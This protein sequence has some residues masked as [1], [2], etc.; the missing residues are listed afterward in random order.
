VTV[1]SAALTLE[2]NGRE[3]RDTLIRAWVV[4]IGA[5]TTHVLL[6]LSGAAGTMVVQV[7]PLSPENSI[8]TDSLTLAGVQ[9]II[10]VLPAAH[11]SSLPG[12]VTVMPD[13]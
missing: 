8:F 13:I 9:V 4:A 3:I 2:T 11:V 10:R 6:P 5:V 7:A 12:D 1:K